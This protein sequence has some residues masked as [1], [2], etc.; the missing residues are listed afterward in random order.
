MVNGKAAEV[1]STEFS[2]HD[3]LMFASLILDDS[4]KIRDY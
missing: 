1:T 3:L 4:A 2:C